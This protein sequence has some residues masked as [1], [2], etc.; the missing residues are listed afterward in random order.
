[1]RKKIKTACHKAE[2][3][4]TGRGISLGKV[5]SGPAG[6]T[7]YPMKLNF[8]KG[9]IRLMKLTRSS[10]KALICIFAVMALLSCGPASDTGTKGSASNTNPKDNP[11]A[12]QGAG[13]LG[14]LDRFVGTWG[15]YSSKS[16]SISGEVGLESR[17][18]K[19]VVK[20]V[21]PG[22]VGLE[23]DVWG[24]KATL[25]NDQGSEKYLLSF[26]AEGFPQVAELP[27]S[28]SDADG[29]FGDTTFTNKGKEFKA[30][31]TIKSDDKG[32]SEWG[33]GLTQGKDKWNL[34]MRLGKEQ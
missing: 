24:A 20:Q 31:A 8:R 23:G 25:K 1:M 16:T 14:R 2:D 5:N 18:V 34:T 28:F 19:V 27:L 30:K 7:A 15:G 9:V 3:L 11:S 10:L 17:W 29:F 22:T 33:L 13:S 12:G 32:G 26:E 6:Q 4:V 21:S